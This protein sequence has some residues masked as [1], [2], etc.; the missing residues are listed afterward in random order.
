[1]ESKRD[2]RRVL[3]IHTSAETPRFYPGSDRHNALVDK[4]HA[5]DNCVQRFQKL[6][7]AELGLCGDAFLVF[8]KFNYNKAGR[9]KAQFPS[10]Q[11]LARTR[12]AMQ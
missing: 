5:I 4:S 9:V 3:F 8:E 6:I 11:N 2:E 10:T 7:S 12:A 1:M